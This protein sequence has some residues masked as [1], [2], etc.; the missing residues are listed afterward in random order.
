MRMKGAPAVEAKDLELAYGPKVVLERSSFSI[1]FG[2]ITAVIGPNG[3]G[4]STILNAIAGLVSPSAGTIRTVDRGARIS[5]VMQS[6]KVSDSLPISVGEVVQMGRYAD[7]GIYRRLKAA[8]RDAISR[9]MERLGVSDLADRHLA[10]LSGGQRQRTFV[11]Q[12]LA[13]SHDILLLDEPLTGIDVVTAMAI[14]EVIHEEVEEG[15]AVVITTHDL[16]EAAASD[17]VILLAGRVVAS[18]P[19][20]EV[21]TADN[22]RAAYGSALLHVDE[23]RVF[24]DD[25][26]HM[27]TDSL[28]VH[29]DRVIH[30]E[31]DPTDRH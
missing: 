27:P 26:A 29:Q 21:L 12:G 25:A 5:Y 2:L 11:A 10:Q 18:G 22:L 24:L 14:D 20:D 17:H 13:Q 28:H 19:P 30:P 3:S 6:T 4:K 16:T 23:G 7:T 9:A 8:D 31:T 1:P 15:C